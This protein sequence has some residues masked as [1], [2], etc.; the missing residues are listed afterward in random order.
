MGSPRFELGFL[1]PKAKRMDQA[2]PR[3]QIENWKHNLI[4][5]NFYQILIAY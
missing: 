1:A 4:F 5:K 2:T 3:A